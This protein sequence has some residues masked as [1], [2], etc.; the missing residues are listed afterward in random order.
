[1]PLKNTSNTLSNL[2]VITHLFI[3]LFIICLI[4]ITHFN[5]PKSLPLVCIGILLE[6]MNLATNSKN[7]KQIKKCKK[8]QKHYCRQ[9]IPFCLKYSAKTEE[10]HLTL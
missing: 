5:F 4:S 3:Y 1:M 7:A 8:I 2:L 9:M 6:S 10:R